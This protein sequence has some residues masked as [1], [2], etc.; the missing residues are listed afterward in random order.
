MEICC[1][2]DDFAFYIDIT[3]S[4]RIFIMFLTCKMFFNSVYLGVK[5]LHF[6]I[7]AHRDLSPSASIGYGHYLNPPDTPKDICIIL[8]LFFHVPL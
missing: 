2:M 6:Q 3:V 5:P 1:A 8:K 7:G 4:F